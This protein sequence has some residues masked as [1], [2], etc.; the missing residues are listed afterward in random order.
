MKHIVFIVGS[1]YPFFS[2]VGT[3][4][5][6]LAEIFSKKYKVTVICL[7][8][9]NKQNNNED[10]K[11]QHILRVSYK[12]WDLRIMITERINKNNGIIKNWYK[13]LLNGVRAKEFLQ[14]IFSRASIRNNLVNSY[15]DALNNM[16]EPIDI[17]IPMC[18]P[19]E[20]VVAATYYKKKFKFV[21]L[22][23][24]LFDSFVESRKLHRTRFNKIIKRKNN[25][26]I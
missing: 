3:C 7:K 25:I 1:Y 21:K 8:N 14:V 2:A 26:K 5:Y 11:K 20:A 18:F 6:N 23:P 17:I 19:M 15:L 13:L 24:Y 12:W 16:E 4:C 9:N 22:I 10:Y